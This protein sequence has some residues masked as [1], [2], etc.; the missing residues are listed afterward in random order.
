LTPEYFDVVEPIREPFDCKKIGA[1]IETVWQWQNGP[2][3]FMWRRRRPK[4]WG[5]IYMSKAPEPV[6]GSVDLKS[7]AGVPRTNEELVRFLKTMAADLGAD[8]GLI[9]ATPVKADGT[10]GCLAVTT[11]DLRKG[12]PD[13]YWG[14]VFGRPYVELFGRERLSGVPA[15]VKVELAPAL[16]YIQLTERLNDVI[17]RPEVVDKA[18]QAA[19]E[20]LGLDAFVTA[21]GAARVPAFSF[22]APRVES[23]T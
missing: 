4:S 2:D 16:F 15:A 11:W 5:G 17:E 13:L 6:H 7:A 9:D 8:F 14:T 19:K 12:L 21:E 18:R 10:E 22:P 1:V 20:H 23:I 3:T